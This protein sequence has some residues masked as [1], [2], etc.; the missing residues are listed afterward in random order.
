[1]RVKGKVYWQIGLSRAFDGLRF[2][3][4]AGPG[5]GVILAG[6]RAP[7]QKSLS[8]YSITIP[9][10][11]PEG[12]GGLAERKQP[13]GDVAD[14]PDMVGA[15]RFELPTSWSQTRRPAAGPRP[16]SLVPV[17]LV[18]KSCGLGRRE[19]LSGWYPRRGSNSHLWLRRP[20]LYPLSY[21]DTLFNW[22]K[23]DTTLA[24]G[25]TS[26]P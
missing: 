19:P 26:R 11:S 25:V 24:A 21:G 16:V 22:P 9:L 6:G 15:G 8:G 1:M 13:L 3:E 5:W 17:A 20:A 7:K 18:E 23:K 2:L 4:R 10:Q 14:L 12:T